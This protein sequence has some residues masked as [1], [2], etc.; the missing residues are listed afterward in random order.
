[1]SIRLIKEIYEILL[2]GARGK[3]K[4][5]GE[6]RKSQNW[7]G[8]PGS[9]LSTATFI[10]PPPKEAFVAIGELELFLHNDSLVGPLSYPTREGVFNERS[11]KDIG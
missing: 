11:I 2:E 6:F 10:P 4:T 3:E 5:P 9:T 1:M 7:I 8:S